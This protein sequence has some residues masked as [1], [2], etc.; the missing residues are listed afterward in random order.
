MGEI[1][2]G[3]FSYF[4]GDIIRRGG[5]NTITIGKYCSI[6]NGVIFDSGFNHNMNFVSTYPFNSNIPACSHLTGHPICKGDILIGND[7]WIGEDAMIMGGVTIG[8]GAVIAARSIVTKDV[9]PYSMVA[10]MPAK[11]KKY[12]FTEDQIQS[13][14][15]IKWWNLPNQKVIENAK[16]LMSGEIDEFIKLFL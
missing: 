3:E 7:V 2:I 6:A 14:L 5:M 12:R 13:L 10:G 8:D 9:K 16:H 15:K 1:K 11:F 4:G